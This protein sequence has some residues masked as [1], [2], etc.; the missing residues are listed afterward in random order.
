MKA[1]FRDSE[2]DWEMRLSE[3]RNA[4]TYRGV[5]SL[6]FAKPAPY[7]NK[8]QAIAMFASILSRIAKL[9]KLQE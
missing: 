7:S 8:E 2:A 9:R 6:F 3:W 4:M 1:L 5:S